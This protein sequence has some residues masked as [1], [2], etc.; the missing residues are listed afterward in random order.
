[1]LLSV[2][3]CIGQTPQQ[4][5]VPLKLSVVPRLRIPGRAPG[6]SERVRVCCLF[7]VWK[8]K[9]TQ[10]ADT[11]A[12]AHLCPGPG[13]GYGNSPINA[14]LWRSFR[15]HRKKGLFIIGSIKLSLLLFWVFLF[16]KYSPT[17][18]KIKIPLPFYFFLEMG[19]EKK[20][21]APALQVLPLLT[22]WYV[23]KFRSRLNFILEP[24]FLY[25]YVRIYLCARIH[26]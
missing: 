19:T 13:I 7:Y 17:Q 21:K 8:R 25:T 15:A 2:F 4:G 24:L 1:M 5:I 26:E 23:Y 3:Q 20:W 22:I 18:K 12:D 10:T 11:M 14:G 9:R 6:V 16:E